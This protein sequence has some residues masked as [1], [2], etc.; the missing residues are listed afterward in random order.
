[1]TTKLFRDSVFKTFSDY[2][3]HYVCEHSKLETRLIHC[4]AIICSI[5]FSLL[6]VLL[7]NPIYLLLA[8]VCGHFFAWFSHFLIEQNQ[9]KTSFFPFWSFIAD[10][11]MC[12]MMFRGKMAGELERC[13]L[14]VEKSD[15]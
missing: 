2:W 10:F 4:F 13:Q 5:L 12:W 3:P 9:P 14:L 11:K 8:L 7:L 6:S 1:M 15:F